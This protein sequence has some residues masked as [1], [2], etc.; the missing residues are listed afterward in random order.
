MTKNTD[1]KKLIKSSG[2]HQSDRTPLQAMLIPE[3]EGEDSRMT[4]KLTHLGSV[5]ELQMLLSFIQF[6]SKFAHRQIFTTQAAVHSDFVHRVA[7]ASTQNKSS[8]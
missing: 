7:A 8:L 3:E 1:W 2:P 6:E 5:V 4:T